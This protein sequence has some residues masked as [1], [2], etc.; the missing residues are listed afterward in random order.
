MRLS[1]FAAL[2]VL[3]LVSAVPAAAEQAA[4]E[5]AV[6]AA[7]APVDLAA[8]AAEP[9]ATPAGPPAGC[10]PWPDLA[11][12]LAAQPAEPMLS[13]VCTANCWDG[14]T[15]TCTGNSCSATDSNCPNVRGQCWSDLEG[16][17]FCPFCPDCALTNCGCDAQPCVKNSQCGTCDGLACFCSG[18][19][20]SK[21]C[22][23][24]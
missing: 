9:A 11:P 18:P 12:A 2:L 5:A 7:A 19:V 22:I 21:R 14:S 24:P 3:A 17:K 4:A 1:T 16:T 10:G 13:G 8:L 20:G 23:C 15:R 6:E